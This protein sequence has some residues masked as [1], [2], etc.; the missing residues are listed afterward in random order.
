MLQGHDIA[1]EYVNGYSIA[2]A[3]A[4]TSSANGV[5]V[6]F[7]DCGPDV[8]S[9]LNLGVLG[10]GDNATCIVKLQESAADS[11]GEYVDITGAVHATK[12]RTSDNS[13][14]VLTIATRSK[15]YV[16][17]VATLAGGSPSYCI[18]V[19]LHSPKSSY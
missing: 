5:G 19:T 18:G 1:N 6:D 12:S 8:V 2:P 9:I 3:A 7:R 11:S 13:V 16:R 17:A 4:K 15:R 14:D 10:G